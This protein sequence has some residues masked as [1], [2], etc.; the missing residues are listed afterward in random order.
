MNLE[1]TAAVV[2]L[3]TDWTTISKVVLILM[4][5]RK[6]S[7]VEDLISTVT[8]QEE[9]TSAGMLVVRQTITRNRD[10]ITGAKEFLTDAALLTFNV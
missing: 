10:R 4:N 9:A 3:A 8:T 7:L 5:V 1:V 6:N 2:Q